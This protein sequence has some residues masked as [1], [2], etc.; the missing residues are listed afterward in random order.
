LKI[1]GKEYFKIF[2]LLEEI[3][4]RYNF[5]KYKRKLKNFN[6][7]AKSV[8]EL[9]GDTIE[10]YLE[11][12]ED[13]ILDIGYEGKCC[14]ISQGVLEILIDKILNETISDI[15]KLDVNYLNDLIGENIIKVRTKCALIGLETI[16]KAIEK[17]EGNS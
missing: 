2:K 14:T 17:Y 11:I 15:K 6:A 8:N 16:K 1:F 5:P 13:K 10:I 9:C 4:Y 12:L 7:F 3:L